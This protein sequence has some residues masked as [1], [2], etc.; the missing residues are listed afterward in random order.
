MPLNENNYE[1]NEWD[2]SVRAEGKRRQAETVST[3]CG[4]CACVVRLRKEER[5]IPFKFKIRGLYGRWVE[6]V[7]MHN[8]E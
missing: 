6:I 8:M 3:M 1:S 5:D 7:T 4:A 2:E